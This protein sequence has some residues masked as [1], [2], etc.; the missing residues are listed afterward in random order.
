MEIPVIGHLSL[1]V[2]SSH[3]KEDWKYEKAV[4]IHLKTFSHG[5]M[6]EVGSMKL[7][8]YMHFY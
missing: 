7:M 8:A 1:L 6:L 5:E 4:R 3:L 2:I